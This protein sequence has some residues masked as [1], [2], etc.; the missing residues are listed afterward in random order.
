MPGSRALAARGA[1]LGALG[2]VAAGAVDFALASARASACLPSGKARL[3][4]CLCA[5]YGA[6]GAAAGALT[7]A[8]LA[9]LGRGTDL[10]GIWRAAFGDPQGARVE[11][12]GA[13]WGAYAL[14]VAAVTI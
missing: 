4:W 10:G 8:L 12:P 2:G 1:I 14:A 7:A 5:L 13:R 9:A 6:A 3:L 11:P